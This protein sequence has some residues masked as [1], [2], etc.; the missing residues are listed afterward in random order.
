MS[1]ESNARELATVLANACGGG[2]AIGSMSVAVYD[3]AWVSMISK[4]ING[5]RCWLFPA[6]FQFILDSQ[7]QGK[8]WEAYHSDIDGILNTMAALL[9]MIRHGKESAINGCPALPLDMD[10]RIRNAT[11]WLNEALCEWDAATSENV[12]FEILVP[13]HLRLLKQEAIDIKF[14]AYDHLMALN[15]KKLAKFQAKMLYDHPHTTIIHSI[16]AFAGELDFGKLASHKTCGSMM[17]SPS[18]TAAY[19]IHSEVWDEEAE[20]YLWDVFQQGQG[21]GTG[22]F[23]S[24]FPSTSSNQAG[25]DVRERDGRICAKQS[26]DHV[27]FVRS[28][29]YTFNSW[30]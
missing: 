20:S 27:H 28:R 9:A 14:P 29:L 8:G 19:L 7:I 17:N 10:L 25:Y 22:G 6:S 13:A 12:G 5:Q 1:L 16:E 2:N 23:P 15:R 4:S 21:K 11:K 30:R 24:A 3:T 18:A 26:I